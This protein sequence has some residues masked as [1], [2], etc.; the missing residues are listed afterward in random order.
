MSKTF[1]TPMDLGKHPAMGV[2]IYGDGKGE[3]M[4]S[5]PGTPRPFEAHAVHGIILDHELSREAPCRSALGLEL[6]PANL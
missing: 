2:W 1:L 3:V 5:Q 4:N 6:S